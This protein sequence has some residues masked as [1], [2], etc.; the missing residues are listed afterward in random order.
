MFRV[1]RLAFTGKTI[2]LKDQ[3]VEPLVST[4]LGLP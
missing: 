3:V 2:S 4:Q 1:V